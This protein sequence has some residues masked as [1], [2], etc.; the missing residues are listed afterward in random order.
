MKLFVSFCVE[1]IARNL[2]FIYVRFIATRVM[3]NPSMVC[4]YFQHNGMRA[5]CPATVTMLISLISKWHCDA[6]L[7]KTSLKCYALMAIVL[8]RSSPVEVGGQIFE[9]GLGD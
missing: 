1:N 2:T 6:N 4:D 5:I 9:N 7:R 8:Q 3:N